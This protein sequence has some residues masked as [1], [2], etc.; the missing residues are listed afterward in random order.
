MVHSLF[1]QIIFGIPLFLLNNIWKIHFLNIR[2]IKRYFYH[3]ITENRALN[4][5][6]AVF[7]SKFL[8]NILI[9]PGAECRLPLSWSWGVNL[10][11]LEVEFYSKECYQVHVESEMNRSTPRA[12]YLEWK[13]EVSI[14]WSWWVEPFFINQM[15]RNT[16]F[17]ITFMNP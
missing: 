2:L 7:V 1:W 17:A 3:S 6:K 9:N 12:I 13:L 10:F 5:Y 14:S 4:E 8:F 11:R 15:S 16:C